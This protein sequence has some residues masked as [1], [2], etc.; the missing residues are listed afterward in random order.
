MCTTKWNANT[1]AQ[2]RVMWLSICS[3]AD[4]TSIGYNNQKGKKYWRN[5]STSFVSYIFRAEHFA[6]S[7]LLAALLPHRWLVCYILRSVCVCTFL[8][9]D[10]LTGHENQFAMRQIVYLLSALRCVYTIFKFIS[11]TICVLCRWWL[12][13]ANI[14]L[15]F[16]FQAP[17]LT[18][19]THTRLDGSVSVSIIVYNVIIILGFLYSKINKIHANH[20]V[21]MSDGDVYAC[22]V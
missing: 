10:N 14:W 15:F 6:S 20:G 1:R 12:C 22:N 19:S 9:T 7:P 8:C 21:Q 11:L 3:H 5:I 18:S 16:Y 2:C 4:P 13:H 17:R